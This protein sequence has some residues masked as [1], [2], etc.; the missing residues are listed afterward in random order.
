MSVEGCGDRKTPREIPQLTKEQTQSPIGS[1][2]RRTT[3]ICSDKLD[4]LSLVHS[5][6]PHFRKK[7][8][9]GPSVGFIILTTA[10]ELTVKRLRKIAFKISR[11]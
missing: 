6:Q 9:K 8:H 2:H 7:A 10:Q 1:F 5:P 3:V 11:N 4:A